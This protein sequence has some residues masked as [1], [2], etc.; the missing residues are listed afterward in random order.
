MKKYRKKFTE[1]LNIL[2]KSRHIINEYIKE[3]GMENGIPF[4]DS[5]T[6]SVLIKYLFKNFFF[7]ITPYK[8]NKNAQIL[9]KIQQ[10]IYESK[11]T[12]KVFMYI[13]KKREQQINKKGKPFIWRNGFK[14]KLEM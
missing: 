5:K 4:V 14:I 13:Y 1:I 7:D 11:R 10:N 12:G 9:R 3:I 8:P 6:S 2:K